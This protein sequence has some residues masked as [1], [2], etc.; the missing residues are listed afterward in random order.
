V[1]AKHPA[2]YTPEEVDAMPALDTKR[3]S[4]PL[5]KTSAH[6]LVTIKDS[7]GRRFGFTWQDGQYVKYPR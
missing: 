1:K 5:D 2:D 7:T 4:A 6:N 3:A